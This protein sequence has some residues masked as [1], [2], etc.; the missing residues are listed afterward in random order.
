MAECGKPSMTGETTMRFGTLTFQE[1]RERADEGWLAIVPTGCTEQQGPHLTV[2]FDTWL[3][4]ELCLAAAQRG[5]AKYGVK[6]LVLPVWPFGSTPE[7]RNYSS[8]YID[9]PQELHAG[10]VAA[11]LDSLIEQGF[12]RLVVWRGCGGHR[13]GQV[14]ERFNCSYQG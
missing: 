3:A 7:H 2:D 1:I 11:V 5:A 4:E 13:L 14:V 8:G 10:V 9:I 12:Q 6:A